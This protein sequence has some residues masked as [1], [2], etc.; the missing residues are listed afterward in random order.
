MRVVDRGTP[1]V[2][3]EM[4][5]AYAKSKAG[6]NPLAVRPRETMKRGGETNADPFQ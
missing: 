3:T 5:E 2:T 1:S 4:P 6:H